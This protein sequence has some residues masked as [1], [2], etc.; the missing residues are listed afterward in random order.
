MTAKPLQS[1]HLEI[2]FN[3]KFKGTQCKL[4]YSNCE[5]I[6]KCLRDTFNRWHNEFPKEKV[7]IMNRLREKIEEQ[8]KENPTKAYIEN[9]NAQ[10]EDINKMDIPQL[11]LLLDLAYEQTKINTNKF[12]NWSKI[13]KIRN[14]Y[15][16]LK[17][18]FSNDDMSYLVGFMKNSLYEN[19]YEEER[20]SY[21]LQEM[22]KKIGK[23]KLDGI[24]AHKLFNKIRIF[25]TFE[26]KTTQIPGVY[27]FMHRI[28]FHEFY[29]ND[30][31]LKNENYFLSNI[32][33]YYIQTALAL[34]GV[35]YE[36]RAVNLLKGEQYSDE[37]KKVNPNSFVPT[38]VVN[39]NNKQE[40]IVESM[41]IL[42]YLEEK[43]P[44]PSLLP[45]DA[46]NRAKVRS[47][48]ESI[49]SGIQPLQ[50]LVILKKV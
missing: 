45:E 23:K 11:C 15:T 22:Y 30:Q 38:L 48:C 25:F 40:S 26:E 2:D 19:Y 32:F 4:I 29:G 5:F 44:Q 49:V 41:A 34:K 47:I 31:V 6:A 16:H 20:E 18:L 33:M 21:Y 8:M 1:D 50:N 35:D 9:L 28:C 14:T 3:D 27:T 13:R 12:E 43:Y 7:K 10:L 42:E 36:Y 17:Y 46:L 24:K 39:E 37:F